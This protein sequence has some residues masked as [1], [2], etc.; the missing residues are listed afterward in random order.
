MLGGWILPLCAMPG[1]HH[2]TIRR[3]SLYGSRGGG[4]GSR[5]AVN[6]VGFHVCLTDVTELK[7][8]LPS[9]GPSLGSLIPFQMAIHSYLRNSGRGSG[10]GIRACWG[11]GQREPLGEWEKL[12][13]GQCLLHQ[14][15]GARLSFSFTVTTLTDLMSSGWKQRALGRESINQGF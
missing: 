10:D 8:L 7:L 5:E 1:A 11:Q 3:I 4:G 2:R 6:S 13:R 12:Q 15:P 9:Q 14:E